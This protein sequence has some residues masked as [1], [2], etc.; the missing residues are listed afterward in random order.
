MIGLP[1]EQAAARLKQAGY[2]VTCVPTQGHREVV[3]E[4]RV[5]RARESGA[6]AELVYAVF[7]TDVRAEGESIA[8][9]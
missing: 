5:V 4:A 6:E 9:G 3:G 1:L 2:S 7:R 8:E